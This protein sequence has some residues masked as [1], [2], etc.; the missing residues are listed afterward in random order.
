MGQV[1]R[2]FF[3]TDPEL[4]KEIEMN[5]LFISELETIFSALDESPENEVKRFGY[6]KMIIIL[7]A[8]IIEAILLHSIQMLEI[9]H[10]KCT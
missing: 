1:S 9:K 10:K 5:Y 7:T 4:R 3:I 6:K 2:F 8:S